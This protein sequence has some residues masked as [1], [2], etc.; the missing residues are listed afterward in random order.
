MAAASWVRYLTGAEADEQDV[1]DA[2]QKNDVAALRSLISQGYSVCVP[3]S[4]V[5]WADTSLEL[6]VGLG[7]LEIIELLLDQAPYHHKVWQQKDGVQPLIR[8]IWDK[9]YDA[10]VLLVNRG[11]ILNPGRGGGDQPLVEAL[12]H[13]DYKM[14]EMLVD[15]GAS[16]FYKGSCGTRQT[17]CC[18]EEPVYFGFIDDKCAD[19][20]RRLVAQHPKL[21]L[22]RDAYGQ[23]GLHIAAARGQVATAK[24]LIDRGLS[25]HTKDERGRT[26]FL[27][28]CR[29]SGNLDMITMLADMGCCHGD[30]VLHYAAWNSWCPRIVPYLLSRGCDP[31]VYSEDD[32]RPLDLVLMRLKSERLLNND[33]GAANLLDSIQALVDTGFDIDMRACSTWHDGTYRDVIAKLCPEILN[34]PGTKGCST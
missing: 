23:N 24:F 10:A 17:T 7:H 9:Q 18:T 28:A 19:L 26:P 32:G 6:A 13:G 5:F 33:E 30:Y 14:A 1:V 34:G 21:L 25:V 20:L 4:S 27:A 2:I 12:N 16:V 31:A 11:A 3:T 8:A 22:E 15:R 29:T